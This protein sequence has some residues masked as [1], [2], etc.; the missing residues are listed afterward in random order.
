MKLHLVFLQ[1]GQVD[2]GSRQLDIQAWK[3]KEII[4]I[5]YR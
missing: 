3:Q 5:S 2:I 4:Y 1:G